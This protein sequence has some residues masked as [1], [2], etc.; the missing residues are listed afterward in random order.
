MVIEIDFVAQQKFGH[1]GKAVRAQRHFADAFQCMA[2]QPGGPAFKAHAFEAEVV[3]VPIGEAK[4]RTLGQPVAAQVQP[5]NVRACG[6]PFDVQ[7][8]QGVVLVYEPQFGELRK[9]SDDQ[10]NAVG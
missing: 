9:A 4:G 10:R 5:A 7:G 2:V 1:Y 3:Q 8:R 6:Q